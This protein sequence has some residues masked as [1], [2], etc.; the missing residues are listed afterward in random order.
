MSGVS[1]VS[2]S[3]S[4]SLFKILGSFIICNI[5]NIDGGMLSAGKLWG[6]RRMSV[7]A[8]HEPHTR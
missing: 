4:Q 1:L 7:R 2:C 8:P 6:M 5:R 3:Q